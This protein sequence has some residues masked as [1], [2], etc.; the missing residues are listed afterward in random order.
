MR[1]VKLVARVRRSRPIVDRVLG[2]AAFGLSLVSIALGSTAVASALAIAAVALTTAGVARS[3]GK[4][5]EV[6]VDADGIS[7]GAHRLRFTDISTAEVH[8]QAHASAI[9]LRDRVGAVRQLHADPKLVR[10]LADR[11]PL[12]PEQRST[13]A[14]RRLRDTTQFIGVVLFWIAFT[15]VVTSLA[16]GSAD[17]SPPGPPGL[18]ALAVISMVSL[19]ER[20]LASMSLVMD[21]DGLRWRERRKECFVAYQDI[22]SVKRGMG[23]SLV[24]ETEAEQIEIDVRD[25][26]DAHLTRTIAT[27]KELAARDPSTEL[28]SLDRN[29]DEVD[30]WR[31]RLR[32]LFGGETYRGVPRVR[33]EAT[34]ENPRSTPERRLGAALALMT[35]A[36]P[37]ER[38]RIRAR[39]ADLADIVADTSLAEAFEE[40]AADELRDETVAKLR[41]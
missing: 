37:P 11:L 34:L 27:I 3:M 30:A 35:T 7:L 26:D 28:E 32:R 39:V 12:S 31:A 29:G 17:V 18:F 9:V 41:G 16:T 4:S 15:A 22:R 38:E 19:A 13:H 20:W 40:L 1:D 33:V 10:T 14:L 8:H 21:P 24:I 25:M 36:S 2:V 6:T 5:M 23:R